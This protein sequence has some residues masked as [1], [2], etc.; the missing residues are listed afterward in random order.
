MPAY[1]PAFV[2]IRNRR[3]VVI[4]GGNIGEEKVRKLLE[5]DADVAVISPEVNE[6]VRRLVDESRVAWD[7]RAY[8]AGDLEGA[9][10]AIAATDDTPTN[11]AIAAEGRERNVLLNVVDVTHLCTFIAPAVARR[12]E[13]TVAVST[14]GASPALAR[15]FREE[16]SGTSRHDTRHSVMEYADL[17]PVLSRARLELLGRGIRLNTD[18]WQA[19]LTDDL[20]ELV[21]AGRSD[22]AERVLMADLMTGTE[23]DCEPGTCRMWEDLGAIAAS[24]NGGG[25]SPAV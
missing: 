22:E 14:G 17:A 15:K 8:R 13:V 2:D 19:C 11:E 4:G 6:G 21:Q 16:L 25:A 18:H 9:F 3:C 24:R 12:G 1:Y 7:A 20:L 23:C 10:L 5:C